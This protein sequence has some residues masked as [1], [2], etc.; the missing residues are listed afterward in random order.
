MKVCHHSVKRNSFAHSKFTAR[1]VHPRDNND[2][3][4]AQRQWGILSILLCGDDER[5][6]IRNSQNR[7]PR[8]NAYGVA[9]F[10]FALYKDDSFFPWHWIITV[11]QTFG[12]QANDRFANIIAYCRLREFSMHPSRKQRSLC[13]CSCMHIGYKLWL[14]YTF[15]RGSQIIW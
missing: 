6:E 8:E 5:S 15:K 4:K 7:S 3:N 1:Y 11:R 10:I 9:R 12:C 13:I 14:C 2:E